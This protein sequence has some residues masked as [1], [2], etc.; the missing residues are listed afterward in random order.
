MDDDD[1]ILVDPRQ[2]ETYP[3]AIR[4]GRQNT[5]LAMICVCLGGMQA[6]DTGDSVTF[7]FESPGQERHSDFELKLM[8][9]DSEQW[10]ATASFV[11]AESFPHGTL[12]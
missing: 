12:L 1:I 10:V 9:I 4:G 5:A 2:L 8:D 7:L 6:E 11:V 3:A